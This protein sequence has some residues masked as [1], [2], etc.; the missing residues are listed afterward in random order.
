M[1]NIDPIKF[2]LLMGQVKVLEDQVSE[3]QKD[4]KLLLKLANRSAGGLLVGMTCASTV[5]AIFS[6]IVSHMKFN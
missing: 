1:D 4:V 2:G 3:L 5:G 6:W